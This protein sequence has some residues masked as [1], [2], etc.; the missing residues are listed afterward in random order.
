MSWQQMPRSLS[1]M[2]D[3]SGFGENL[4]L[5]VLIP[6]MVHIQVFHFSALTSDNL[7]RDFFH[8]LC[9]IVIVLDLRF[10]EL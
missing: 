3:I 7:E 6:T 8:T 2:H 1:P 9:M 10:L 4:P 5:R